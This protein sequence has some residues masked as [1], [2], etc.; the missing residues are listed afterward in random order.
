MSEKDQTLFQI[1]DD[2]D[3]KTHAQMNNYFMK[4]TNIKRTATCINMFHSIRQHLGHFQDF[5]HYH[6]SIQYLFTK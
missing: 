1:M 3:Q 2:F 4:L 6:L 5:S